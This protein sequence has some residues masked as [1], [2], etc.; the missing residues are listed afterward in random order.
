MS[1]PLT[2]VVA[3]LGLMLGRWAPGLGRSG[4]QG[5][6]DRRTGRCRHADTILVGSPRRLH[7]ACRACRGR[8]LTEVPN[9]LGRCDVRHAARHP[10]RSLGGGWF[11]SA[12]GEQDGSVRAA[13]MNAELVAFVLLLSLCACTGTDPAPA[14]GPSTSAG[15][16]A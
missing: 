15:T 4:R 5:P 9:G 6:S 12:T 2:P 8:I 1:R 3:G 7:P 10:G 16:A 14:A 13:R 11:A